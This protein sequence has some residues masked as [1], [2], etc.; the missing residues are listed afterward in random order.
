LQHLLA[1]Q[2]VDLVGRPLLEEG[3]QL[4]GPGAL[5]GDAGRHGVAAALDQQPARHR[6]AHHAA[7]ITVERARLGEL[8]AFFEEWAADEV[9]RLRGEEVLEIDAALS[10]EGA[11]FDLVDLIDSAGPYGSGHA[12]PVLALPRHTL[13]DVRQVGANHIR[14][15]LR[16]PS[17]GRLQAMAF[18]A[19]ETGLGDFLFANRGGAVHVVGNLSSN[20][21]N[22][23]R[24]VQFRIA[25]AAP[26]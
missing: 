25:D 23:S 13:V 5:D 6:L 26:A 16:S 15:D 10:A 24:S 17:G 2:A 21:W 20:W 19:V 11:T 12:Q 7:G 18:R 3:A 1:A 14:A 22:G 4:A 8:R 9:N